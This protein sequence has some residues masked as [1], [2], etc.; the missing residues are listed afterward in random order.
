MDECGIAKPEHVG[1]V[2]VLRHSGALERLRSTG[3]PKALQDQ[4]GHTNA[5]MTIRYMKTLSK[6]ETLKIQQGVD[7]RW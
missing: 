5:E 6:E 7:F 3:N 1:A 4:L 2:H